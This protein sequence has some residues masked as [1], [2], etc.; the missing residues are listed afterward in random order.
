[1][2]ARERLVEVVR[3]GTRLHPVTVPAATR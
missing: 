1:V 3:A 2:A